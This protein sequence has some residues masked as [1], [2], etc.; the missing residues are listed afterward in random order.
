MAGRNVN[1][2]GVNHNPLPAE[3]HLPAAKAI[4]FI[5]YSG[6]AI[7]LPFINIY[8]RDIGLS[9]LEIGIINTL[10]P[11]IGM[12][13]APLWGILNDRFGKTRVLLVVAVAGSILAC[14]GI[15][16]AN[17]FIILLPIT[18][19]FSLFYSTLVPMIDSNTLLLLGDRRERYGAIRL[20]G[21][22]GYVVMT[23]L[24]GLVLNWLGLF[25]IFPI[26]TLCMLVFLIAIFWY[27]VRPVDLGK[28]TRLFS[29][30]WVMLRQPR[31]LVFILSVMFMWV[32]AN[33]MHTF[34]GVYMKD[35]GGDESLIGITMAV[36]GASEIPV[37]YYGAW[38]LKRFA[39]RRMIAAAMLA[40]MLRMLLYGF[41][42]SPIWAPYINI[43]NGVTFG[44]FWIGSIAYVNELAP[45]EIKAT[46]QG[47]L[48]AVLNLASLISTTFSGWL[49]DIAGP[50]NMFLI[51]ALCSLVAVTIFVLG[52]LGNRRR[53]S[54]V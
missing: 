35:L 9:G 41:M 2:T 28:A 34:L 18:G 22:I 27:P 30:L 42:P 19:L 15:A 54:V 7:Y 26:F 16:A 52:T 49:Y 6:F 39:P 33:G 4:Y 29:S 53:K 37:M 17:S 25:W 11:L 43:L 38:L 45:D 23:L 31:W 8:Y 10:S 36:A 21:S 13:S 32:A 50:A 1:P 12:L 20:W 51:F 46:S 47:L 5:Y 24:G 14:W 3:K 48:L 44:L 40:Y